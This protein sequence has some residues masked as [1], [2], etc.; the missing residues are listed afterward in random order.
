MLAGILKPDD[1]TV[2]IP[3]L[4]ISYK[5][6]TIAPKF[7][8]TVR[9]LLYTK[10]SNVLSKKALFY[11]V[12]IPFIIY[13][14]AFGFVMY[15]LSNYIHPEALADKL[16]AALGPRF[17][18]PLAILRIWSFCLFYVMAEL[19]GSVVISVL[20][21]GFANQVMFGCWNSLWFQLS[22]LM[23]SI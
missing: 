2:E 21:W 20:F 16:L 22:L 11:T 19:W 10:L 5:P 13:F 23:C 3:K 15:P 17:M 18:G 12:I 4:N 9:D 1:P 7:E 8:G 14:G 6:Q